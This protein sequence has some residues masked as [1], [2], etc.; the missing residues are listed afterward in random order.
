MTQFVQVRPVE[1]SAW[2]SECGSGAPPVLIDVREAWEWQTA[3]VV[4]SGAVPQGMQVIHIP[5]QTLPQ[6]VAELN[7]SAPTALLCHH[8]A[9]SLSAGHWLAQ[10]GFEQLANVHGGIDAWS[11]NADTTIPLY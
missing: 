8:G 7:P 4:H 5:L 3:N 9:R 10:Q 2:L 6:R 1:L 11:R